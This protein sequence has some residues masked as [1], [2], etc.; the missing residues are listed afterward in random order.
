MAPVFL[1]GESPQTEVSGRIFSQN[2][3]NISYLN[4]PVF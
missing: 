4:K 3:F 1:P 2:V